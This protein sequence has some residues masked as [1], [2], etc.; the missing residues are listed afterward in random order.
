MRKLHDCFLGDFARIQTGPFGSQLHASDYI[1]QGIPVIMPTNIG[2]RLE[3]NT[4]NIAYISEKDANRLKRHWVKANDIVYSRRGDI[5]K[6]AFIKEPQIN[7]LCGTGCLLVRF[8]SDEVDSQFCAF[9][10]STDKIKSWILFQPLFIVII[11]FS[12]CVKIN[13]GQY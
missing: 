1:E 9:Y 10:L 4:S 3:I 13:C 8:T 2:T 6:C 11:Y 12:R 7:W 5:E